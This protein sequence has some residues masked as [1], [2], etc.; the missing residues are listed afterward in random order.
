M[1]KPR[2]GDDR[3]Y[4]MV[5]LLMGMAIA[6]VWMAATLPAW[7]QQAVRQK[8]E[9][10][11]FR[12]QQYARALALFY[13]KNNRTLPSDIDTLV[14][15]RYLRKKWKDPITNDDFA[16]LGQV[17][18]PGIT[19]G[20]PGGTPTGP[21]T[22]GNAGNSGRASTPTATTPGRAGNPTGTS[23]AAPSPFGASGGQNGV[24]GITGVASKSTDTSIKIY[25]NQQQYNLWQFTLTTSGL[26][27][28]NNQQGQGQPGRGG[29]NQPGGLQRPGQP[30]GIPGG[31]PGGR[32][33]GGGPPGAPPPGGR[34]R[35][36][37]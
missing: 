7:R 26:P 28:G 13:R 27:L 5:I 2:N 14:S 18:Q 29:P 9:E 33:P 25:Q 16:L 11:I 34:G 6:A 19:N 4:V 37:L 30:G 12:G 10:L 20:R 31:V 23:S 8:E 1:A 21:G 35:G 17:A 36:G 15:G 22:S 32:G 24:G 3:G